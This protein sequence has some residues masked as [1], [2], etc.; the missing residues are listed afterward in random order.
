MNKADSKITQLSKWLHQR[1]IFMQTGVMGLLGALASLSLPPLFLAPAVL[2]FIPFFI[3]ASGCKSTWQ[4]ILIFWGFA[5]GWF[6]AS[7]YWISASL[8]VDISW[9]VLIL[10]LSLFALPAFLSVFWGW[11][12]FLFVKLGAQLK[13]DFY[14]LLFSL[15]LQNYCA[16]YYSQDF[17]GTRHRTL[18]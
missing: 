4:A 3:H 17:L 9:E 2:A 13:H 8:F 1:G 15:V 10:P 14:I 18:S 7:L 12:V 16:R 6:T 5:F 11:L